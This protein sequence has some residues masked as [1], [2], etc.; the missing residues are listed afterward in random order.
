MVIFFS[1]APLA[2]AWIEIAIDTAVRTLVAVAPLAG[3]WIEIILVRP[4]GFDF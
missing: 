4:R 3:A 1:V 2:G